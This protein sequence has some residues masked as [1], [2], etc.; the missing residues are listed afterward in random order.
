MPRLERHCTH[1][2]ACRGQLARQLGEKWDRKNKVAA[3]NEIE[4]VYG[5][6]GA[7][8]TDADGGVGFVAVVVGQRSAVQ[9]SCGA[10]EVVL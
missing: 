2:R 9:N 10:H 7:S 5:G 6:T 1:D 4:A 8:R 3:A